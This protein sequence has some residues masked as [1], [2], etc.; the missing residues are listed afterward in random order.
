MKFDDHLNNLL[1]IK[2]MKCYSYVFRF[3]IYIVQC[4]TLRMTLSFNLLYKRVRLCLYSV[5]CKGKCKIEIQVGQLDEHWVNSDMFISE[6]TFVEKK[7]MLYSRNTM[8]KKIFVDKKSYETFF[9]QVEFT[10]K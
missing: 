5:S 4:L 10:A 8:R 1:E 7:Y 6:I 9:F 3:D 2:R